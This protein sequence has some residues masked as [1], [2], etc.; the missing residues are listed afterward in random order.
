[1]N[2]QQA[3]ELLPIITA[4]AE[5]KEVQYNIG[6]IENPCWNIHKDL[7]F[8]SSI[9]YYRIKPPEPKPPVYR[10]WVEQE[11]PIG[12]LTRFKTKS[13]DSL[14][15]FVILNC[16]S[17]GIYFIN[18]AGNIEHYRYLVLLNNRE[19]SLDN[20]KTWLPCGVLVKQEEEKE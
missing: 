14:D 7:A 19:H 16:D 12:A 15:C 9:K 8:N 11:T 2:Q 13:N 5:G 18:R 6:T 4:F 17:K 3:K 10:E 1:M 20:G